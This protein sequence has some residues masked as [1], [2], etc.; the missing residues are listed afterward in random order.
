MAHIVETQSD[1]PGA[2]L[3]RRL[4]RAERQLPSLKAGELAEYLR[5]LDR[6]QELMETL[7]A[8]AA[9]LRPEMTRW[10]DLQARHSPPPRD[11]RSHNLRPTAF[12]LR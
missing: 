8:E 6:V 10:L 9:D 5:S 2:E 11:G 12:A 4:D 7:S 3:R 1:A